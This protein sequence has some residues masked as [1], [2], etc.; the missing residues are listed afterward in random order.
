M[1][2]DHAFEQLQQVKHI[3]VL[4]MENRSFDHML[5]YLTLDGMNDV[6]GLTGP[7]VNVNLDPDGNK[8]PIHAFDAEASTVQRAGEA[9]QKRLDP[10]HSPKGVAIQLGPGYGDRPMGGF[11]RAFVESRKPKDSVGSDLWGSSG[12]FR[13]SGR[14]F[15]G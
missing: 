4:M 11:V 15:R 10:D 7:D 9:L 5:G 3:V 14:R 12:N 8:V 13:L 1:T 2:D 6:D